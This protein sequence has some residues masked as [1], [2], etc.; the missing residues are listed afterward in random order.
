MELIRTGVRDK[1]AKGLSYPVGAEIISSALAGVPQFDELWISFDKARWRSIQRN[2]RGDFFMQ[3]F[4]VVLNF[5]S[6]GAYLSLSAV[7]SE[8]RKIVKQSIINYGLP[9]VKAWLTVER[10]KTWFEG[11]RKFE[12]GIASD[13][14]DVC[15]I[16]KKNEKIESFKIIARSE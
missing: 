6:G 7:P 13:A 16:E 4:V 15:F 5:N 1:L 12:V 3:A 11:F 2:E 9:E 8:F 14:G 10:P